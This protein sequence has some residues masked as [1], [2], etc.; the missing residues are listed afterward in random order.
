MG[1][2]AETEV[3]AI[4][5][6]SGDLVI[7]SE[8]VRWLALLPGQHVH[9]SVHARP[10]RRNMYGVLAGRIPDIPPEGIARV[11]QESWGDLAAGR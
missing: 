11:R 10:E 4:V 3:E 9:V 2:E 6:E 5:S 8:S 1:A 7:P